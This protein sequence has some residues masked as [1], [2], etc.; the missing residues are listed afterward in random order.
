MEN[1]PSSRLIL[2]QTLLQFQKNILET[3][4]SLHGPAKQAPTNNA[5]TIHWHDDISTIK[6]VSKDFR[7]SIVAAR[8]SVSVDKEHSKQY[9]GQGSVNNYKR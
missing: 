9:G 7:S 3:S 6:H 2:V 8:E 1:Q 5:W 4:K